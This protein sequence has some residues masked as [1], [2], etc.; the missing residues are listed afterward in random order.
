MIQWLMGVKKEGKY[1]YE[2]LWVTALVSSYEEK[3]FLERQAIK[4]QSLKHCNESSV[5]K[6]QKDKVHKQ[7]HSLLALHCLTTQQSNWRPE[8]KTNFTFL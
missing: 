3:R 7:Y 4:S 8:V 6:E 5:C 2:Y 1:S